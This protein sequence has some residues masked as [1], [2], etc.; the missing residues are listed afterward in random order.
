[1]IYKE[2]KDPYGFLSKEWRNN[3]G[4][5]HREDGPARIVYNNLGK[6]IKKMF[7]MNGFINREYGPAIIHYYSNHSI[8]VE[9][10]YLKQHLHREDG[11]AHIHYNPDGSIRCEHFDIYDEYLG[12]D[13]LGFWRLWD[14][15]NEEKRQAPS[16]LKCLA[17]YS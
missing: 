1:M 2:F 10:F 14:K 7:Y 8:K 6:I 17:R 3:A 4:E 16:L 12:M 15:L 9:Y 13:G 11:P 5:L